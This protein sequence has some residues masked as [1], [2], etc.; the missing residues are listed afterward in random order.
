ML[1]VVVVEVPLELGVGLVLL[2]PPLGLE[3]E[4]L[5]LENDFE[6]VEVDEGGGVENEREGA[7]EGVVDF[8]AVDFGVVDFGVELK[9]REGDVALGVLLGAEKDRLPEPKLREPP[10]NPLDFARTGEA[11][12]P[13]VK[14]TITTRARMRLTQVQGRMVPHPPGYIA[15]LGLP[16][17]LTNSCWLS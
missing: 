1:G 6:S 7:V 12:T 13:N 8:G 14:T 16:H 17:R 10:E 5:P 4:R 2:N 9:E 3:K 15:S 11:R